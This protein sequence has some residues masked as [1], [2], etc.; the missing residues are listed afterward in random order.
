MSGHEQAQAAPLHIHLLGGLRVSVGE[1]PIAEAAWRLRKARTLLKLLALAPGHRLHREQLLDLLWPDLAPEAAINNLH[2]TLHAARRALDPGNAAPSPYLVHQGDLLLLYPDGPLQIDVEAFESA[3][4]RARHSADPRDYHIALDLYTGELLPEDRYDDWARDRRE[5]VQRRWLTLLTE[6]AALHEARGNYRSGVDLL[7]RA[8]AA[9]PTAEEAHRALIRLYALRGERQ[10]ALQQFQHLCDL[11]DRELGAAPE[12]A[13]HDLHAAILAGRYP[14]PDTPPQHQ[15][16]AEGGA[17]H[18]R[19]TNLPAQLT[20]FIG[21]SREMAE[22]G[23]LLATTRLLTLTGVGGC[24]KTRLAYEVAAGLVERSPDSIWG[25]ELAPLADPALVA[26]AVAAA[27]GVAEQPGR[28]MLA[29]LSLHLRDRATLLVLDNCEHLIASC[30]TLTQALLQDCPRLRVLATSREPLHIPG[31]VVWRVPSLELPSPEVDLAIATLA[32]CEAV[33]LFCARAA[34]ASHG[35]ALNTENAGE[36]VRICHRL[37]GIP[38]ALELAAARVTVLTP[39]QI[40]DRLADCFALLIAGSRTAPN[41]QQ[42]L[43]ATLDWSYDLLFDPERALLRRLAVFAGEF[44]VEA[45]EAV[46]Q[47]PPIAAQDALALL[48]QL[49][50]KSLV[51]VIPGAHPARYRLLEPVRQYADGRLRAADEA[52]WLQVRHYDWYLGLARQSRG[53][54]WGSAQLPALHRLAAVED[55]AR[56]ALGWSLHHDPVRGLEL[57]GELWPYWLRRGHFIEGWQW[58]QSVLAA[59]PEDVPERGH[60]LFGAAI[61]AVRRNEVPT[62]LRLLE[63]GIALYRHLGDRRGIAC[64]THHLALRTLL[65]RD[66]RQ[67]RVLLEESLTLLRGGEFRV[68]HALASY[69]RGVLAWSTGDYAAARQFMEEGL[70]LARGAGSTPALPFMAVSLWVPAAQDEHGRSGLALGEDTLF[71]AR[72]FDDLTAT[73]FI[74]VNL[75]QLARTEGDFARARVLQEEGLALFQ[76][77]GD[78]DGEGQALNLLGNL[79]RSAGE[80]GLARQRLEASLTLRRELADRRGIGMTLSNL[81]NLAAD[82]GDHRRARVVLDESLAVFVE[83]GDE[84]GL[85]WT[86]LNRGYLG[87]RIGDLALAREHLEQGVSFCMRWGELRET[88][89]VVALL[90]SL[91]TVTRLQGDTTAARTHLEATLTLLQ[92]LED[93]RGLAMIQSELG[94]LALEAGASAEAADHF[95]KSLTYSRTITDRR[96]V[97]ISLDCLA[98]VAAARG[99]T[100]EAGQLR[101]VAGQVRAASGDSPDLD[102]L[103]THLDLTDT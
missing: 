83:R 51:T 9:E 20:S 13:T 14:I 87:V 101:A 27:L 91:G 75:G 8:I 61:L 35:F 49:V 48:A 66:C 57:A 23:R 30:A 43:R 78:R 92:E 47:S 15:P 42:T 81:A 64:A 60:A 103:L 50:D 10:R 18:Q 69:T 72:D 97:A 19:Q 76:R 98:T 102:A 53:Q 24:G 2:R 52:A 37:D 54:L 88:R 7:E 16:Q 22:V 58:F 41:R 96:C 4:A 25:V 80:F 93:W 65:A 36:I 89:S 59:A 28:S 21:R 74:L 56:A 95:R 38:L 90:I 68:E 17:A 1:R 11:L 12:E 39:G 31:E 40:A 70:A 45:V 44:D 71:H 55:N 85:L 46:C 79:A 5:G 29:T 26:N 77:A 67:A 99:Q 32:R 6:L 33:D 94:H 34:A 86:G 3:A 84:A 62:V 100:T 63:Q 73:A 82:E